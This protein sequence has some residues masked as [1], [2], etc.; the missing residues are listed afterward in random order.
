MNV[1]SFKKGFTLTE[2][3]IVI[4][5]IGILSGVLIPTFIN[6]VNK[7]NKAADLSLIRNLNEALSLD[8]LDHGEHK[9]MTDALNAA[10]EFGFEV[11]KIDSK[12]SKNKILWDS[13]NDVFCYWNNDIIEYY[14]DSVKETNKIKESSDYYKLWIIDDEVNS[15]FST[16]L[17]DYVDE[18][19]KDNPLVANAT[20]IDTGKCDVAFVKY[21]NEDENDEKEIVIRTNSSKTTLIIEDESKGSIKHYESVGSLNIIKC[22]TSSYHEYGNVSFVEIAT[23]RYAI[24]EGAE[25]NHIHINKK[26][27]AGENENAF[28]D[29]IISYDK[30]VDLTEVGFSR[31]DVEIASNGTLV[32]ALQSG[33]EEV[34]EETELDYVW[35]TKQGVYEQITIS[36]ND[37]KPTTTIDNEEVSVWAD[38]SDKSEETKDAAYKIANNIS[39]DEHGQVNS[40]VEIDNKTY[41]V[42]F[43]ENRNMTFTNTSSE[44]VGENTT[45]TETV[46]TY[47]TNQAGDDVVTSTVT[48]TVTVTSSGEK[49]SEDIG[50]PTVQL[51]EIKDIND[52]INANVEKPAE[53]ELVQTGARFFNGGSGTQKD[54]Y[55]ITN[56]QELSNIRESLNAVYRIVNDIDMTGVSSWAPIG[57]ISAPFSGKIDGGNN[58]IRNWSSD[59][60]LFGIVRG[61]DNEKLTGEKSD[62]LDANNNLIQ[63]NVSEENYTCVIK[64]I[65]FENCDLV[66]NAFMGGIADAVIDA[67]VENLEMSN[68]NIIY[69]SG[70]Y[71]AIFFGEVFKSHIKDLHLASSNTITSVDNPEYIGNTGLLIGCISGSTTKAILTE[72]YLKRSDMQYRTIVDRC[73]NDADA[74]I[75]K[76]YDSG[77]LGGVVGC[78]Y[79]FQTNEIIIDCVNNGDIT[80]NNMANKVSVGGVCGVH[81]GG[82]ELNVIRC[83]NSGDITLTGASSAIRQDDNNV[84]DGYHQLSG[85]CGYSAGPY[86]DC[87]NSGK[88]SGNVNFIGGICGAVS[89]NRDISTVQFIN[90]TDNTNSSDL[91]SS[92]IYVLK[93]GIC[94]KIPSS[95]YALIDA[96]DINTLN[97]NPISVK[98]LNADL[99][100]GT[101]VVPSSVKLIEV[102]GSFGFANVDLSNIAETV[103]LKVSNAIISLIGN[104]STGTLK[105]TGSNNT[106][107]VASNAVLY[108]IKI[109]GFGSSITNEGTMDHL[110]VKN[111]SATCTNNGTMGSVQF[112]GSDNLE[113]SFVNN[114]T[115]ID[116]NNR[117]N[118]IQIQSPISLTFTNNGVI[119]GTGARYALLFYGLST[120]VFNANENSELIIDNQNFTYVFNNGGDNRAVLVTFNVEE[121]AAGIV[122]DSYYGIATGSSG[123]TQIVVNVPQIFTTTL[124]WERKMPVNRTT[125][126]I[127]EVYNSFYYGADGY[128]CTSNS[129]VCDTDHQYTITILESY[130]NSES[131]NHSDVFTMSVVFYNSETGVVTEVL[132]GGNN[133]SLDGKFMYAGDTWTFSPTLADSDRFFITGWCECRTLVDQSI[134]TNCDQR[135]IDYVTLDA[136]LK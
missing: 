47:T 37:S 72:E 111:T 74:T 62:A 114:G 70:W 123:E 25:V 11:E 35:L 10:E 34:T 77:F 32:V 84:N 39:R 95:T 58:S 6:V 67:Y 129:F 4:V 22:H 57:T 132:N 80:V 107:T 122:G 92:N 51:G 65:N 125:A 24:E 28:A 2:L 31:D 79:S 26:E 5:I 18:T 103:E 52:G 7:A 19:D 134:H 121:G 96:S 23:G 88:I 17:Y 126:N 76:T 89:S 109:D 124:I 69:N 71:T 40:T 78:V 13:K 55:L 44:I 135:F 66:L 36:D 63:A 94:G 93:G 14:P 59:S 81:M 16:Y 116:N 118:N 104:N 90:C 133:S 33:T 127:G 86:I 30:S 119:H 91:S 21:L 49:V 29:I 27:N 98:L 106:I 100:N 117:W 120:V 75:N 43:D 128:H 101:L 68:S 3:I 48:T 87:S 85:V 8:K 38:T 99:A 112:V 110:E 102:E 1:K 56:P 136:D 73:V 20:G 130:V 64:N 50:N 53:K 46:Y 42:G 97:Y 61:T 54:P 9:H 45:T 83:S 12:V 82:K 41:D 15:I 60:S 105:V 108:D 113:M 131:Y 115:I